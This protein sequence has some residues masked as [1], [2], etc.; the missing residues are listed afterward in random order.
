MIINRFNH[1]LKYDEWPESR[2][3]KSPDGTVRH[4]WDNKLHKWDGPAVIRKNG[5]V[6]FFLYGF[7]YTADGFKS[8]VRDRTGLP[9]YKN[10]ALKGTQ[11]H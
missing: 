8:A 3:I 11:R 4:I 1:E 2:V 9:W 10:P 5:K 6:E 7:E